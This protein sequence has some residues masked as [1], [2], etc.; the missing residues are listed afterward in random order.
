MQMGSVQLLAKCPNIFKLQNDWLK[1][2]RL[3]ILINTVLR[4]HA[5]RKGIYLDDVSLL[6][7]IF[8]PTPEKTFRQQD[9]RSL[10]MLFTTCMTD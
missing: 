4:H 9:E 2:L 1:D 8:S 6:T 10:T 3:N 7:Y 5:Q